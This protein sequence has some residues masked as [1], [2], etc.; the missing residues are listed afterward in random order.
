MKR[1]AIDIV[2]I[3]PGEI[4]DEAIGL[5]GQLIRS[6][7]PKIKLGRYSSVPHISLC[8]G[9]LE[10]SDRPLLQ[11]E[12]AAIGKEVSPLPLRCA[13]IHAVPIAND[14]IISGIAIEPDDELYALHKK[15]MDTGLQYLTHNATMETIYQPSEADAI[16]LHFINKY[17]SESAYEYFVPHIT[18]GVGTMS[19]PKFD[20]RFTAAILA[21]YHL[22]NYCTCREPLK[23]ITLNGTG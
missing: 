23:T 16:T 4:Q 2:L 13:G 18:L 14:E 22:G 20:R 19:E 11:D 12:L 1:R 6:N 21:V 10:E 8:M 7:P 5:N 15:V 9:V 17:P 3:P